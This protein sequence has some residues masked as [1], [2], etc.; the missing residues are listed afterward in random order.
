MPRSVY[1]PVAAHVELA[2]RAGA[3]GL[4]VGPAHH[5]DHQVAAGEAGP[6][7]APRAPGPN[8][9]WPMTSRVVPRR[10]PAVVPAG[11]LP[12]GPADADREAV[13]QQVPLVADRVGDVDDGQGVGGPRD[14][15]E[16]AHA[17]SYHPPRS[18]RGLFASN[19]RLRRIRARV[20]GAG[21]GGPAG[22]SVRPSA[23]TGSC[24]GTRTSRTTS[25]AMYSS[26]AIRTT[27]ASQ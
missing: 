21:S 19:P 17:P 22:S 5:A 25:T 9:S 8:D 16:C 12:V 23:R 6:V 27:I 13:D 3:A 10:R 26:A 4:R 18:R 11:D 24:Q 14:R 20:E 15:R 1:L 7:G 2:V